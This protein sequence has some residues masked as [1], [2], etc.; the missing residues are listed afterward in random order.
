MALFQELVGCSHHQGGFFQQ[1]CRFFQQQRELIQPCFGLASDLASMDP[2]RMTPWLLRR[3]TLGVVPHNTERAFLHH[4]LPLSSPQALQR[5]CHP[6]QRKGHEDTQVSAP[7][8]QRVA[9]PVWRRVAIMGMMQASIA[10]RRAQQKPCR[11][12]SAA[13]KHQAVDGTQ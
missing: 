4:K 7:A 10:L 3:R 13:V 1:Q 11:A 6:G 9:L 5:C 8:P 12:W 2:E